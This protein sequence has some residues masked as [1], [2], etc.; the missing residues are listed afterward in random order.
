MQKEIIGRADGQKS[1]NNLKS[2]AER[3]ERRAP[4]LPYFL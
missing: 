1:W 4:L 2:M 3:G